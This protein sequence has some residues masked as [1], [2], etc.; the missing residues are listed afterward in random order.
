MGCPAQEEETG[1]RCPCS[2][3]LTNPR[4]IGESSRVDGTS[5]GMVGV[6]SS[7]MADAGGAK[8][9]QMS[10]L[11]VCGAAAT[12]N[13]VQ[14]HTRRLIVGAGI[15]N[16]LL[17]RL[18]VWRKESVKYS[19]CLCKCG[20]LV[21]GSTCCLTFFIAAPVVTHQARKRLFFYF[22]KN[23]VG[24]LSFSSFPSP[25]SPLLSLKTRSQRGLASREL[26]FRCS[27]GLFFSVLRPACDLNQCSVTL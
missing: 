26:I 16:C 22:F 17:L 7:A 4:K 5:P 21:I 10:G 1:H 23:A 3:L 14:T 25:P 2:L 13:Q 27:P 8:Q 12:S 9:P 18:N 24:S 11:N 6:K 19:P 20:R 15:P